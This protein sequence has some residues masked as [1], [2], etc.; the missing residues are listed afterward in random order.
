M[1]H[2]P[3]ACSLT[4]L[5]R[6]PTRLVFLWFIHFRGRPGCLILSL[7]QPS[8]SLYQRC[9]TERPWTAILARACLLSSTAC[10]STRETA[11]WRGSRYVHFNQKLQAA[12]QGNP[13]LPGDRV[14][15][16]IPRAPTSSRCSDSLY[17]GLLERH[18]CTLGF[19][20]R[21]AS[22]ELAFTCLLAI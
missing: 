11:Q 1:L 13:S 15:P 12:F 2:A 9:H 18:K 22:C 3:T 6:H 20:S 8:F 17:S 21:L 14:R 19:G 16:C 7:I 5:H 4:Q 10:I